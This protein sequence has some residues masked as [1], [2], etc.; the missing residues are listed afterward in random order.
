[1]PFFIQKKSRLGRIS[2]SRAARGDPVL[3]EGRLRYH[4]F[5]IEGRKRSSYRVQVG[6]FRVFGREKRVR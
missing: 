2:P 4:V 1:M 6:M 3:V 5:T